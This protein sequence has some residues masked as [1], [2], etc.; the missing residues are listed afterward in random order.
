MIL[1]YSHIILVLYYLCDAM[2]DEFLNLFQKFLQKIGV[3]DLDLMET[4]GK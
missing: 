2:N 4:D 1:L 3:K